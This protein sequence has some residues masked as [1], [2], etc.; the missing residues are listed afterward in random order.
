[1]KLPIVVDTSVAVSALRSRRG[2][3]F[4]VLQRVR[5]GELIA[6]ASTALILEYESVL[7]R[8][9][10]LVASGLYREN[11]IAF[12]DDFLRDV[13][14]VFIRYS[15]RP[16]LNDP[17]DEHVL[18]A[19]INAPGHLLVT[20]NVRHFMAAAPEFRVRVLTPPGILTIGGF[21]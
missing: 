5:R 19:A 4:E 3:S 6:Y 20:H 16:L 8:E 7:L 14:P 2:A 17:D 10:H 15:Y 21:R 11:A 12:L 9:E 18:E 13:H 1:V